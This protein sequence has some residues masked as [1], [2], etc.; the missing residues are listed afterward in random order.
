ME[1]PGLFDSPADP[2][3]SRHS[4][5]CQLLA[6]HEYAYYVLGE[7]KISDAAY[8]RF[9][10][11]LKCLEEEHPEWVTEDSPTQRVG[12]P[13]PEGSKFEKVE[14]AVPMISIESLFSNEDIQGFE[15]RVLKG[16]AGETD[17]L[18][19]YLCEPKWDGVSASLVYEEG[20]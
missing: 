9:F 1:S 2:E 14:H 17:V 13:L 4:E 6:E 11:Q 8:D 18:P 16:L 19:A 15:A 10:L 5:L 3:Q 12:A 7:P 20:L